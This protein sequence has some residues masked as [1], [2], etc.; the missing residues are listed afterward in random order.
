M[1]QREKLTQKSI[2][3][4]KLFVFFA[5]ALAQDFSNETDSRM[6]AAQAQGSAVDGCNGP[7]CVAIVESI[8]DDTEALHAAQAQTT[9]DHQDDRNAHQERQQ[10]IQ[11]EFDLAM[12]EWNEETANMTA[13]HQQDWA[14]HQVEWT[15]L[16]K[17]NVK[18]FNED[19]RKKKLQKF[20]I[21]T[22][23]IMK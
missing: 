7:I 15:G 11:A 18:T 22:V 6:Y 2:Q 13:R 1:G 5:A 10:E 19:I 20:C 4:M 17:E 16:N 8:L 3:K 14:D 23:T 9:A 12:A 21:L